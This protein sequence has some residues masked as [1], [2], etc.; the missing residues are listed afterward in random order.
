M[1]ALWSWM[2]T[3]LSGRGILYGEV[4]KV[5]SRVVGPDMRIVV[6]VTPGVGRPTPTKTGIKLERIARYLIKFS[7]NIV[8]TF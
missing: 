5:N 3:P 2:P 6:C 7:L 8:Y 4:I 1:H